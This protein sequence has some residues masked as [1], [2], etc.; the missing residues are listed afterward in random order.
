MN[1]QP[2]DWEYKTG[3]AEVLPNSLYLC[4]EDDLDELLYGAEEAQNLNGQGQF[5]KQPEP[6]VDVWVDLR[7]LRPNNRQVF[8]PE[9]VQHLSFPFQDGRL[10]EAREHLPIA[11]KALEKAL[12]EGKRVLVSCHQGRSRSSLLLLQYL[13]KT[14]ESFQNSYWRLKAQ[15][16]NMDIDRNFQPLLDEL[17]SMYPATPQSW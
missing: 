3:F 16:P 8:I 14:S 10:E 4:G 2:P 5:T 6:Q 15:R 7:D 13:C 11:L 1:H 12:E 9:A 17:K